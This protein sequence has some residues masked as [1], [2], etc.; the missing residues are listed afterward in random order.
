M[1]WPVG[2]MWGTGASATQCEGASPASD[3]WD[4]ER[5]GH[6]PLSGDG[7]GFAARY[8]EDFRLLAS[9]GLRHHRLTIDW[10]RVEPEPGRPDAA[11]VAHYRDMLAAAL[12][13]GLE[14]WVCLHH[15]TLPRW[16]ADAG[17]F[18]TERNRVGFWTRHVEFIAE[19]FGDLAR[20]WQPVN[21]T[22]YYA[23]A[24]Y[25]G[26]GW[27]PG[28][29]DAAEAA[30]VSRA[31]QLATA[32]AAMRLRQT[33]APVASIFG[34]SAIEAM[35]D[36]P[37]TTRLAELL[38]DLNWRAGL[39][40][41]RDGVL[42]VPGLEVTLRPDLAGSFDLIGFSFYSTIG[43]RQGRLVPYP[44]D[45]PVSPLGYGI[46]ADGLGRVLDRLHQM[47]PGTPL[48]VAEYGIGT[49]DDGERTAYLERGLQVTSDAIARGIDVRGLF[50]WTAVDNYEWLHGFDVQFGLIDRDR[51]IRP[52]ARVFQREAATAS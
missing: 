40:L 19:T 26:R 10:A 21:E 11:A 24:A 42:R 13:A 16:F 43:I 44:P 17:G 46:W 12:E 32:E 48:L 22:N 47:L 34:L 2:F 3:W 52:S 5:A 27:P 1:R 6:A 49:S 37:R 51:N 28:H 4:W 7:N 9:L 29:N 20:G 39:E 35:D 23:L 31:M 41:F 14:P 30:Q 50:H 15:F 33:G 38:N 8:A 18:L 45:A 25:R 36:D